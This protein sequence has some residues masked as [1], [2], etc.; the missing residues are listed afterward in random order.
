MNDH[1]VTQVVSIT[2]GRVEALDSSCRWQRGPSQNEGVDEG[3]H[4]CAL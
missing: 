2:Q 4:G 3:S 1:F